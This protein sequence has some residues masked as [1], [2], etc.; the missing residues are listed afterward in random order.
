MSIASRERCW[1]GPWRAQSSWACQ[2]QLGVRKPRI[3][4][5]WE[6]QGKQPACTEVGVE[7]VQVVSLESSSQ[8]SRLPAF[9]SIPWKDTFD[10]STSVVPSDDLVNS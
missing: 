6:E 9:L 3:L 8:K 1:M 5:S 10:C 2:G 4:S 7:A